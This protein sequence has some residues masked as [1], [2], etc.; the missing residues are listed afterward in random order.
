MTIDQS[1]ATTAAEE[2]RLDRETFAFGYA[3]P[4][5]MKSK[6]GVTPLVRSDL[7][8]AAVQLFTNGGGERNVHS[9]DALDGF[10]FVLSGRAL[11]YDLEDKVVGDLG[12]HQGIFIPRNAAYWFEC[13]GDE[14][15]EILQVEA[16]DRSVP[17]RV[18]FYR[19]GE[20]FSIDR[21]DRDGTFLNQV[22]VEPSAHFDSNL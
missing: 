21:Y 8:V 16:I 11:F 22:T 17:N 19:P 18:K 15:L 13:A 10:W 2:R 9:H 14:P 5:D 7:M 1:A 12:R 20:R 6:R 4:A 3:L